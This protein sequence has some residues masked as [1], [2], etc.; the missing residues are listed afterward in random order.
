MKKFDNCIKQPK[1]QELMTRVLEKHNPQQVMKT[2]EA[3]IMKKEEEK[4]IKDK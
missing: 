4:K 2:H 3:G 1:V